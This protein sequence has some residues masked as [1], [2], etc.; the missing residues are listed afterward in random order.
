MYDNRFLPEEHKIVEERFYRNIYFQLK[1]KKEFLDYSSLEIWASA[2]GNE[3]LNGNFI[4][5]F[6]D[7]ILKE[8]GS[9]DLPEDPDDIGQVSLYAPTDTSPVVNNGLDLRQDFSI[10]TGGEDLLGNPVPAGSGY[11]IGAIELKE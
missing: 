1:G 10:D 8:P 3:M 2:T 9:S 4:G 6:A 11:D 5:M 7:P